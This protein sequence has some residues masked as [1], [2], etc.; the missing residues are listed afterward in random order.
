MNS[1]ITDQIDQ[2]EKPTCSATMDQI[3]L[4]L[5]M[6]FPPLSQASTSSASQCSISRFRDRDSAGIVASGI[7]RLVLRACLQV[8][9]R[10]VPHRLHRRDRNVKSTSHHRSVHREPTGK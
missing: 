5:A 10:G 4:R 8:Y 3:R 9:W 7:D 6:S 2:M 1:T